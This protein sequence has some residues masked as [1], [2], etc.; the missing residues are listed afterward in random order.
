MIPSLPPGRREGVDAY[1]KL[2]P[3]KVPADT[4]GSVPPLGKLSVLEY[5]YWA[6]LVIA[7]GRVGE[8]IGLS[9]FP[10]AK[11][12]LAL[13][14]FIRVTRWKQLPKLT[15]STKPF[16]VAGSWLIALALLTTLNSV[17]L[18]R[19]RAFVL[20]QLPVL[21]A[22]TAIAYVMSRSW[23]MLRGTLL[24]L[25]VAGLVIARSS[26]SGYT[27]GRASTATMYDPNDL[28]YLLV[29]VFPLIVGFV[30]TSTTKVW[31]LVYGGVGVVFVTALLL[32]QSRGGLI[33]LVAIVMVM[34]LAPLTPPETTS[35]GM[36]KKQPKRK[37]RV[38]LLIGVASLSVVIWFALPE[39]ARQR[40]ST[41]L[42]LKHDYNLDPDDATARG[43][44]WQRGMRA[45][46]AW[47]LGYGPETFEMVDYKYGGRF[48]APHNCYLQVAVELGVIGLFMFLRMYFLA[49]RGLQRARANLIA[50]KSLSREQQD[51]A[52]FARLLQVS[53]VGNAIAGFFLSMAY[54]PILWTLFGS[55]MAAIVL[56]EQTQAS[57]YSLSAAASSTRT[58]SGDRGG[59]PN[60]SR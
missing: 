41:L 7:I 18:G 34:I 48:F 6:F 5:G 56:S 51:L 31:R 29:T 19:S 15:A 37:N 27:G 38:L 57:D 16:A 22:S 42:D 25:V 1:S 36:P 11:L 28:A 43:Q 21:L 4:H 30:L 53:L 60:S 54:A 13:P 24:A 17:W 58:A 2:K 35:G 55:V 8:L 12:A 23:K 20:Q 49:W 44:I 33:G 45:M 46:F 9:S 52:T 40:F 26:I 32:T 39:D 50:G 47:P 3:V 59:S 14:L 10:L